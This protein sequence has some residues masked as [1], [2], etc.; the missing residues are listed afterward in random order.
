MVEKMTIDRAESILKQGFHCSQCVLWHT[1]ELL[2]FEKDQMLKLGAGLGG[3]GCFRGEMCGV[4]TAAV[5]TLGAIYGYNQP[6][7]D[8][9]NELM[10]DRI[11]EFEKRFA[12]KNKS[13][14]CRDL[15]GGLD[16]AKPEDAEIISTGIHTRDCAEYCA[17]ACAILDDMLKG[18]AK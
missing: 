2:G 13:L 4:V 11:Q 5:V 18:Y 12:E 10:I 6:D 16:F 9:Q 1:S 15:L 17:D 7:S 14:V 3:G 8:E